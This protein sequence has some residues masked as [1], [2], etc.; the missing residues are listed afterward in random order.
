MVRFFKRM[1]T[2]DAEWITAANAQGPELKQI[3]QDLIAAGRAVAA[4]PV[5]GWSDQAQVMS[6]LR[7]Y[8]RRSNAIKKVFDALGSPQAQRLRTAKDLLDEY[9]LYSVFAFQ[10][11]KFHYADASGGPGARAMGETGYARRAATRRVTN[12][13]V[14]FSENALKAGAAAQRAFEV[15]IPGG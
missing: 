12:N 13:G 6:Q 8:E 11:G 15:F 1:Q 5:M 7:E 3:A 10:W 9:F 4:D 2:D 14:K